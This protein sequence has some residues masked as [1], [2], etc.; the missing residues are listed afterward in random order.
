MMG[1]A[2]QGAGVASGQYFH[3]DLLVAERIRRANP[4][5]HIDVGS[6][7]DGFVAHVATFREIEVLDLRPA[8][9]EWPQITFHEVDVTNLPD[10]WVNATHSLSSLHAI[11]HF[12][13]GRYGDIID[14][15]GWRKGI[16]GLCKMLKDDGVLYFS[17]PVGEPQ[18]IEF[19]AHRIFSLHYLLNFI[20]PLFEVRSMSLVD[21]HGHL[22]KDR[23]PNDLAVSRSFDMKSGLVILELV[24][25]KQL[26]V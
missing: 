23:D 19:N 2:T 18:R 15:D 4:V 21:D 22:L 26:V 11:E 5:R 6:R 14:F 17:V 8:T 7:I 13:L 20:R 25:R 12:G 9:S 1:E 16:L 3:Q 24:K 10:T